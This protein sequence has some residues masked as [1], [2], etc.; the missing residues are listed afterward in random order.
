M[1][2]PHEP[3]ADLRNHTFTSSIL[4]AVFWCPR[5]AALLL[6]KCHNNLE[7]RDSLFGFFLQF[8]DTQVPL[9][10]TRVFQECSFNSSEGLKHLLKL[11]EN[12]CEAHSGGMLN[13]RRCRLQA[14]GNVYFPPRSRKYTVDDCGQWRR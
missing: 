1:I 9:S 7:I 3:Q 10:Y 6:R 12:P 5:S 4:L 2:E 14:L 13:Q 11:L 8:V